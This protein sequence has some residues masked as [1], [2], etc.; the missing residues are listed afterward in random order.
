VKA[1]ESNLIERLKSLKTA[2]NI[3]DVELRNMMNDLLVAMVNNNR[4]LLQY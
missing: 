4:Y 1:R 3:E 2:A